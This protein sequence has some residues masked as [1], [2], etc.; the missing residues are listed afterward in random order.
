MAYVNRRLNS[1]QLHIKAIDRQR[2]PVA[3]LRR[4]RSLRDARSVL[5][6]SQRDLGREIGRILNCAALSQSTIAN[7][8]A[9]TIKLQREYVEAIGRLLATWASDRSGRRIGVTV[10]VN[11][12]WHVAPFA[13]CQGCGKWFEVRRGKQKRCDKCAAA[14][15]RIQ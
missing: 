14:A 9:K 7:A 2:S 10:K 8:E 12:P 4:V 13:E 15:A 11:S 5:E 3:I 6:L 1:N